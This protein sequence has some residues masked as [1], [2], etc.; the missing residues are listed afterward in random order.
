MHNK[1]FAKIWKTSSPKHKATVE[2]RSSANFKSTTLI[3]FKIV[4][5]A[6]STN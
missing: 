6:Y 5:V 4:H 2:P 1:Y 3:Y